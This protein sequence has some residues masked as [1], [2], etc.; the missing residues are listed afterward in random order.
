MVFDPASYLLACVGALAY[1][2]LSS[3]KAEGNPTPEGALA[4]RANGSPAPLA[5][6]LVATLFTPLMVM[7]GEAA[8]P[9]ALAPGHHGQFG[10]GAIMLGFG[11]QVGVEA[12]VRKVMAI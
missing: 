2:A 7:S 11:V 6:A 8:M 12:L 9:F 5:R 4:K 3:G 10:A 1:V